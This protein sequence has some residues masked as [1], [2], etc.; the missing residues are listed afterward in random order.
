MG[1][2]VVL[3][4]F[5]F[6]LSFFFILFIKEKLR[7]YKYYYRKYWSLHAY[8]ITNITTEHYECSY[9]STYLINECL[10]FKLFHICFGCLN[11]E[12]IQE[13]QWFLFVKILIELSTGTIY[14]INQFLVGKSFIF[15]FDMTVLLLLRRFVAWLFMLPYT[16]CG[17]PGDETLYIQYIHNEKHQR[18]GGEIK[19]VK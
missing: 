9:S 15:N 4:L 17:R 16:V 12:N 19:V 18:G 2:M 8:L 10:I 1:C 5:C 11:W 6:Q 7:K 14:L 13:K 3:K